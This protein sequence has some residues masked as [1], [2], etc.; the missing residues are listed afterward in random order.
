MK[1]LSPGARS[2]ILACALGASVAATGAGSAAADPGATGHRSAARQAAG[3]ERTAS[4]T[5]LLAYY[6]LWFNH[7]SWNRAKIDYPLAGRYSSD[8]ASVVRHQIQQAK[9]AGIDGFIV[10]WKD[11]PANDQRLRLLMT[12]AGQQHFKLAM[13]YQGLDFYRRPLPVAEVAADFSTFRDRYASNPVFFRLDGKPLTIWSG[14]WAFSRAEVARVTSAVRPGMLV[15]STEKSVAGFRSVAGVTDG[16]AYYWSSVNPASN[17]RYASKL[18]AMS[19]A[20]HHAGEYWIAPFAPGFNA[21]L[22]GGT[23]VVPRDHG[24]TLRTE[25]STAVRSS[26][27]VL[28]LISWN[29]FSENTYVEPSVH[30]GYQALTA[31]RQLRGSAA[32]QPSGPGAPSE[33]GNTGPGGKTAAGGG[34]PGVLRVCGLALALIAVLGGLGYLR[35]RGAG[36]QST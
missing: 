36:R 11:T 7:R 8:D 26:P 35:R 1:V 27:D 13:I 19:R 22:V 3:T 15:L 16:D 21:R 20:V 10:S 33:T 25:Y 4:P 23:E 9:S 32:P 28:G 29:E 12:V 2:A 17:R 24:Q 34:W 14:T 5:P 31:L 6:Y 18:D 30:Y